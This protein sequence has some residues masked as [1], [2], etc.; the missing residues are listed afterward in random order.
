MIHPRVRGQAKAARK[1]GNRQN[2]TRGP[3]RHGSWDAAPRVRI[4]GKQPD[5]EPGMR[6]CLTTTDN[7]REYACGLV[8][9]CLPRLLIAHLATS[10]ETIAMALDSPTVSEQLL[11][12]WHL[13]VLVTRNE[14]QS[15]RWTESFPLNPNSKQHILLG[16]FFDTI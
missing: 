7:R 14:R 9:G 8:A 15:C 16:I 5:P 10:E 4:V 12:V 11:V 2:P 13:C 1:L 3:R 6:R